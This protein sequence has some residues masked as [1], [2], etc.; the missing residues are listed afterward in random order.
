MLQVPM[1]SASEPGSAHS[2]FSVV[3]VGRAAT[4]GHQNVALICMCD[5]KIT[6]YTAGQHMYRKVKV[7]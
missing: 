7:N 3:F 1:P 5:L 2:L 4:A 6:T